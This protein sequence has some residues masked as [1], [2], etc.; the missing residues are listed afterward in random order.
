MTLTQPPQGSEPVPRKFLEVL[1]INRFKAR[2]RSV[3]PH[4]QALRLLGPR[5]L[6]C[7]GWDH[8]LSFRSPGSLLGSLLRCH[9]PRPP[10]RR[11]LR[12]IFPARAS[13]RS[14]PPSPTRPPSHLC[15]APPGCPAAS[16][17]ARLRDCAPR[18]CLGVLPSPS[19][20][21]RLP[22]RVSARTPSAPRPRG[23]LSASA[24][25]APSSAQPRPYLRPGRAGTAAA[26]SR[27]GRRPSADKGA[28]GRP[29]PEPGGRRRSSGRG[30]AGAS[31]GRAVRKLV[32]PTACV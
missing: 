8:P 23:E 9:H 28:A 21:P 25:R 7:P 3:R 16:R 12:S 4:P 6:Q 24:P 30:A 10:S 14:T 22:S 13:L 17:A 31:Q 15:P 19:L 29:R 18:R 11:P 20:H 27:A 26:A 1:K 32:S 5:A 2:H